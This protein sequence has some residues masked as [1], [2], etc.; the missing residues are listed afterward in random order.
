MKKIIPTFLMSF[1]LFIPFSNDQ[2][3]VPPS[4]KIKKKLLFNAWWHDVGF[5]WAESG[6]DDQEAVWRTYVLGLRENYRCAP[7]PGS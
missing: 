1:L 5:Y 4:G 3:E 2:A 6:S 7:G